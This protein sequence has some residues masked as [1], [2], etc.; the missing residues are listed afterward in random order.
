MLDTNTNVEVILTDVLNTGNIVTESNSGSHNGGII[1]TANAP[2]YGVFVLTNVTNTGNVTVDSIGETSSASGLIGRLEDDAAFEVTLS[3]RNCA[4]TGVVEHKTS[5][6]CG[7]FNLGAEEMHSTK[8]DL[9]NC[10]NKG[11]VYGAR[12]GCGIANAVR[13]AHNVLSI[14]Y[15]NSYQF[16]QMGEGEGLYGL[17]FAGGVYPNGTK[18]IV[19]DDATGF[20]KIRDSGE[21]VDALLNTQLATENSVTRW[22]GSLDVS[23]CITLNVSS[24]LSRLLDTAAGNTL[25][26]AAE[27][28][29]VVLDGYV[30]VDSGADR[31]LDGTTVLRGDTSVVL[32]H[33]LAVSGAVSRRTLVP[34]GT[35]L[36]DTAVLG[37]FF[38]NST[39]GVF[40]ASRP[41]QKTLCS[42]TTAVT[43]DVEVAVLPLSQIEVTLEPADGSGPDD[44]ELSRALEVV[45]RE[46]GGA[47]A[48]IDVVASED[49]VLVVRIT[50]TADSTDSVRSVLQECSTM[51]N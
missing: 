8:T 16:W 42:A 21:W 13:E 48:R 33:W 26:R 12:R 40:D 35:R 19:K 10:V 17:E 15:A 43:G 6:A 36:G 50:L 5:L 45:V 41:S 18:I 49:G 51:V 27:L 47:V 34:H 9:D 38:G 2:Q 3:L 30:W 20:Y 4:N 24:P 28:N 25:Q 22:T 29:G 11:D 7:L 31:V 39:V 23:R 46:S 37:A 14:G 1:G 32:S 44:D